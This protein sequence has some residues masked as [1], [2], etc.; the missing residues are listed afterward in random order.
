MGGRS[1]QTF[2]Q[3]RHTDGQQAHEK[4]LN[5]TKHRNANQ[6]YNE[7]SPHTGQ[8]GYHQKSTTNKCWRGCKEKGTL[9]HYWWERKS[10]QPLWKTVWR[11]LKKLKIELPYDPAIPLLG[12][13]AEK[14]ENSN[15][16]RYVHPNVH[17]NTIY[18]D[19]PGGPVVK[20]LCFHCRGCGFNPW[21]GN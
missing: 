13:Y 1:K 20:T 6:N 14:N 18:R 21:S 4:I 9:L 16:K 5:I 12:I 17:S 11:F 19:F 3:R 8:N 7:V 15:S 2:F 10:V